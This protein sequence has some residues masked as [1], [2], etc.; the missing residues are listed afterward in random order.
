MGNLRCNIYPGSRGCLDG[1]NVTQK[2]SDAAAGYDV[3]ERSVGMLER[4]LVQTAVCMRRAGGGVIVWA[5]L[6]LKCGADSS[7]NEPSAPLSLSCVGSSVK[8]RFT[9]SRGSPPHL[10]VPR[11]LS[12]LPVQLE[13]A[14]FFTYL[15]GQIM[16]FDS[17]WIAD[18][19]LF[20]VWGTGGG[21]WKMSV[22]IKSLT[23]IQGWLSLKKG[24]KQEWT[25]ETYFN[26]SEIHS[27]GQ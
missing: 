10:A 5:P 25:T 7:V 19:I 21:E 18:L 9:S 15:W 16:I 12:L 4:R 17:F 11:P 6:T 22:N 24:L 14:L 8:I 3:R 26:P 2:E 27:L 13:L 23:T 20:P 1:C